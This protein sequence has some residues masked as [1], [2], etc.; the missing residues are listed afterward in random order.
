MSEVRFDGPY[1]ESSQQIAS[2]SDLR[3]KCTPYNI[4]CMFYRG[5]IINQQMECPKCN[6][7]TMM[8]IHKTKSKFG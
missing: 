2:L 5:G 7:G 3:E 8:V 1:E 4:C 6:D